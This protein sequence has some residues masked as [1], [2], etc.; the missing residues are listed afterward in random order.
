MSSITSVR[1]A[2]GCCS[3]FPV[4]GSS[5]GVAGTVYT[6]RLLGVLE[7]AVTA[8]RRDEL[9]AICLQHRQS[10]ADFHPVEHRLRLSARRWR[11]GSGRQAG[12][13]SPAAP[14]CGRP[15]RRRTGAVA[16]GGGAGDLDVTKPRARMTPLYSCR[17]WRRSLPFPGALKQGESGSVDSSGR[18]QHRRNAL[19]TG[20]QVD[21]PWSREGPAG[22]LT[23]CRDEAADR[24][25][26]RSHAL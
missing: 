1:P 4:R 23:S 18:R 20:S 25:C 5:P 22:K 15:G 14:G 11:M 21:C 8:S 16:R 6:P 10:R 7:L 24:A 26:R 9:P 12:W 19:A 13:L 3:K 17:A 2:R